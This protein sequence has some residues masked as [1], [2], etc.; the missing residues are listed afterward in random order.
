MDEVSSPDQDTDSRA[1]AASLAAA[2]SAGQEGMTDADAVNAALVGTEDNPEPETPTGDSDTEQPGAITEGENSD[3]SQAEL[4]TETPKVSKDQRHASKKINDLT[5]EK[6]VLEQQLSSFAQRDAERVTSEPE[7][8]RSLLSGIKSDTDAQYVD[9]VFKALPGP[10][11]QRAMQEF[12]AWKQERLE[13]ETE[14]QRIT[15]VAEEIATKKLAPIIERQQQEESARLASKQVEAETLLRDFQKAYDLT[16]ESFAALEPK[17]LPVYAGLQQSMP[18]VAPAEL[19]DRAMASLHPE[20]VMEQGRKSALLQEAGRRAASQVRTPSASST[21]KAK[22][23][24]EEEERF[25]AIFNRHTKQNN[26]AAELYGK[27]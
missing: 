5:D 16:E 25:T 22:T 17:L 3:E 19:L 9:R 13:G 7:H 8:F 14:E 27:A 15:R 12:E 10:H 2:V 6:K 21:P 24:T 23:A 18:D 1:D 26:S 4:E 11:Q 20:L